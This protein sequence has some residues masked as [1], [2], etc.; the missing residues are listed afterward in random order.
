MKPEEITK[1]L[2]WRF[3]ARVF[4]SNKKISDEDLQAILESGRLAPSSFGIEPWKFIVVKNPEV[5]AKLRV[6]G[7]D[8]AKIT[9]ASALVII[10]QRTDAENLSTELIERTAA[11]QGKTVEDLAGLKAMVDGAVSRNTANQSQ[12]WLKS[13]TYIP[14]GMMIETASLLGIDNGPM[15]GF[16]KGQVDEILGLKDKNLTISTMLALGYRGEEAW[17]KTR[18][19]YDEV[20]EIIA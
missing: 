7:Y 5:R 18:R 12:I 1:A 13:Q 6:A 3:A 20:V 2:A 15:E 10:A 16:D 19:A 11:A 9:D 14:L 4:D 8:Q 17:P